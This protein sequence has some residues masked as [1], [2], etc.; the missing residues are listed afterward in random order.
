[1]TKPIKLNPTPAELLDIRQKQRVMVEW[2]NPLTAEVKLTPRFVLK[3]HKKLLPGQLEQEIIYYDGN[4]N[5]DVLKR[6]G[7]KVD[8]VVQALNIQVQTWKNLGATDLIVYDNAQPDPMTQ[9]VYRYIL[10]VGDV[11]Y[12]PWYDLLKMIKH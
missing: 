1:M 10:G 4:K 3:G 9:E 8:T 5:F 6:K 12:K 2:M 11:L 7:Y